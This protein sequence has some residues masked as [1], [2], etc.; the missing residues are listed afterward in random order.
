M[1]DDI[2]IQLKLPFIKCQNCHIRPQIWM[3]LGI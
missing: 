3:A 1:K 2:Y